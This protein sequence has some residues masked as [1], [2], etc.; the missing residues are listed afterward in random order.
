M[1]SKT[2]CRWD[3]MGSGGSVVA[4][5]RDGGLGR[6]GAWEENKFGS[7][8]MQLVFLTFHHGVIFHIF[9]EFVFLEKIF[10]N[11]LINQT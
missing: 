4:W 10:S 1:I 7:S 8:L 3:E 2:P 6:L 11:S 5:S 9:K